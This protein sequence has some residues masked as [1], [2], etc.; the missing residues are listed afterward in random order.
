MKLDPRHLNLKDL[1]DSYRLTPATLAVRTTFGGWIPA[2]HLQYISAVVA[3]AIKKGRARLTISIPP[4]HGKSEF[5][6]VHTPIWF[7]ENFPHK[8]VIIA[9]Y[10]ADL[11][12]GFS[13]RVRD[14]FLDPDMED[15][16]NTRLAQG[17]RSV[18]HFMTTEGG[19][20]YAMGLKGALTG[21]GGHL[22]LVDDYIKNA[23]ESLSPAANEKI[24]ETFRSTIFTRLEPGA[25]IIVVA[26]R[27]GVND[28]IGRIHQEWGNRWNHIKLPALAMPND[29]LGR[30]VGEPL[31]PE[32]YSYEDLLEIKDVLGSYWWEAEYQQNPLPSMASIN[33]AEKI[34]FVEYNELPWGELKACRGWDMAGTEGSGDWTAGV[35]VAYHKKSDTFYIVDA[36]RFQR[37]ALGKE[38]SIKQVAQQDTGAVVIEIEQE[39]GSSG[40][41]YIEYLSRDVLKE[42]SVNG[43]KP[44]GPLEARAS[45]LLAALESSKGRC[46][47]VKGDWNALFVDEILSF[48]NGEHDD[49]ISAASMAFNRLDK[50]RFGAV[51]WGRSRT[52]PVNK[53]NTGN[54]GRPGGYRKGVIW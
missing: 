52:T 36:Q 23:E 16:L 27:W 32:R 45:P 8:N 42:F 40:K 54:K 22:L 2:A 3:T 13:L 35:L 51:V 47:I 31:W 48:P 12:T 14:T 15:I 37:S 39:P 29:L 6:S 26:T 10:G 34:Q 20:L 43:Y 18:D 9:S 11:S 28:L 1:G 50:G 38:T 41:S 7:Q 33:L 53:G 44:T 25:S 49:Q 30:E 5:C 21:R 46:K 24:F 4:R 17:S 19:N